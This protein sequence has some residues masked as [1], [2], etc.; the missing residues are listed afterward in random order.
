MYGGGVV[1]SLVST[2]NIYLIQ[3]LHRHISAYIRGK[4]AVIYKLKWSIKLELQLT[5]QLN[6]SFNLPTLLL[7]LKLSKSYIL[8]TLYYTGLILWLYSFKVV[9]KSPLILTYIGLTF[10]LYCSCIKNYTKIF[11]LYLDY[12]IFCLFSI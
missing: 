6:W 8:L 9:K 10:F 3:V 5:Y 4:N 2:H 11:I 7:Y 1:Q 12:R